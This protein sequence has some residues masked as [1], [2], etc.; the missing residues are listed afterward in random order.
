MLLKYIEE[1]KQEQSIL[2]DGVHEMMSQ[3]H[4]IHWMGKPKNGCMFS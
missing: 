3:L 1:V 4:F 2:S